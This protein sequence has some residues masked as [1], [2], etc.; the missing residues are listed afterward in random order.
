M[1][2]LPLSAQPHTVSVETLTGSGAN[3]PVF[4][5]AVGVRCWRERKRR[6][7]LT[8]A[9]QQVVSDTLLL[10]TGILADGTQGD[11]LV[12]F[13][14]GSRV[15]GHPVVAVIHHDDGDMGAWQHTEVSLGRAQ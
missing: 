6:L 1:S 15:D 7:V 10:T 9:G 12:L 11:P 13:A 3:G 14:E 4:A 8:A 5:A 2:H